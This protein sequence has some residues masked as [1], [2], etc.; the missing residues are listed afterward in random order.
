M[1]GAKRKHSRVLPQALGWWLSAAIVLLAMSLSTAGRAAEPASSRQLVC[2]T[3]EQAALS[4]GLPSGFLARLLWIESRYHEAATSPAGAIGI[5]QFIPPTAAERGLADPRDPLKAIA[6][7][8]RFL[9]EL[10]ARFGNLGLAAAAYNA[11]AERI[12]AWLRGGPA[13]AQETRLY[14]F[15][16][17]ARRVE[18]WA[19]LPSSAS[20]AYDTALAGF[21][22]LNAGVND[23][24]RSTRKA[25]VQ[26]WQARLALGLAR[27]IDLFN[28]SN[29]K[30]G[31]AEP[32]IQ[33]G[34]SPSATRR[35]ANSLC[36]SLRATGAA[37]EV[38][39]R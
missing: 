30:A 13:L 12:A 32:G 7:A 9:A 21:D 15:D 25:A 4:N 10:R 14:V 8:A 17:T 37:C 36:E 26:P 38:F 34:Q 6:E 20:G 24:A 35:E 31:R 11:G 22:C 3:I 33:P 18:D 5:A 39:D 27:A 29:E 2:Q 16:I 23:A 28:A 19:L 1:I